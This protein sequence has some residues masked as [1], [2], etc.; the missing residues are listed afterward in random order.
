MG[1]SLSS[2]RAV[3]R[4]F[5]ALRVSSPRVAPPRFATQGF[6][7]YNS[8]NAAT[9]LNSPPCIARRRNSTLRFVCFF[10]APQLAATCLTASRH[11][12]S[13]LNATICLLLRDF[14]LLLSTQRRVA[15]FNAKICLSIY[16]RISTTR[17]ALQRIATWLLSF[18]LNST[19]CL[20][21]YRR[22]APRIGSPKH[23]SAR[24]PATTH[25]AP[26]RGSWQSN[27]T[28]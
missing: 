5:A 22:S 18:Q 16:H 15:L 20:S 8:T 1:I 23:F 21:I 11:P 10:F 2:R 27:A 6:V 14:T 12:A 7:M 25:T 19:I 4:R 26:P 17:R 3:L 9:W 24:L 28:N 13:H